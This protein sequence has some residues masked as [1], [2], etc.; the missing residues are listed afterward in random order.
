L[1]GKLL[2]DTRIGAFQQKD[3]G[4]ITNIFLLESLVAATGIEPFANGLSLFAVAFCVLQLRAHCLS[5]RSIVSLNML[6][7]LHRCYMLGLWDMWSY[8]CSTAVGFSQT[9][10]ISWMLPVLW[11][12]KLLA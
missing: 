4:N 12:G 9:Y 7:L 5:W 1:P 11:R 8:G 2:L 3:V 10:I 6:A